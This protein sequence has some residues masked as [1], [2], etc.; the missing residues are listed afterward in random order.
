MG[1]YKDQLNKMFF[2]FIIMHEAPKTYIHEIYPFF[3]LKFCH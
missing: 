2:M 3:F 1:D